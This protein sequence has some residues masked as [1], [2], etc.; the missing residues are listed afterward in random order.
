MRDYLISEN[1][2]FCVRILFGRKALLLNPMPY[3]VSVPDQVLAFCSTTVLG[4]YLAVKLDPVD[5]RTGIKVTT[6][7]RRLALTI[8][9][10]S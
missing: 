2:E 4:Y 1:P 7:N 9:V 8:P 3:N 5:R 10:I 6:S